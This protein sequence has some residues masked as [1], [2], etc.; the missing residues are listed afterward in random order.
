MRISQLTLR[1][2]ISTGEWVMVSSEEVDTSYE[3]IQVDGVIR[4]QAVT[5][6]GPATGDFLE[7]ESFED[8]ALQLNK[9]TFTMN[10]VDC[11]VDY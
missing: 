7:F 5:Y 8:M 1:N 6:D 11:V 2:L 9:W 4:V 3:I 10:S